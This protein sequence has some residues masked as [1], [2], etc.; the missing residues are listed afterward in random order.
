MPEPVPRSPEP[1]LEQPHQVSSPEP[2]PQT[3]APA[4]PSVTLHA[5]LGSIGSH[6]LGS[7]GSTHPLDLIHGCVG[8]GGVGLCGD[9]VNGALI[10]PAVQAQFAMAGLQLTHQWELHLHGVQ[11]LQRCARGMLARGRVRARAWGSSAC[12]WP[13]V[14]AA[15]VPAAVQ[16]QLAAVGLRLTCRWQLQLRGVIGIQRAAR[17]M[18]SRRRLAGANGSQLAAFAPECFAADWGGAHI[19]ATYFPRCLIRGGRS[20]QASSA[21]LSL[22][23]RSCSAV[24]DAY[25]FAVALSP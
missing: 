3:P 10:P 15:L 16:A 9:A 23:T 8:P 18:L 6:S 24:A 7:I 14:D 12:K 1:E 19:M 22:A 20:M 17:G 13:A 21:W 25:G 5:L 11:H 4:Q 2:V